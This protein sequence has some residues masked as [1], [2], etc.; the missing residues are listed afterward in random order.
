MLVLTEYL[1][2][3]LLHGYIHLQLGQRSHKQANEKQ[4]KKKEKQ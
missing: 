4:E 2:L 1:S 3:L